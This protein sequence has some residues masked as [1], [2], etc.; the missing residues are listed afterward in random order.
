M[1][2]QVVAILAGEEAPAEIVVAEIVVAEIVVAEEAPEEEHRNGMVS[3]LLW[4]VRS[5]R[6]L[7]L[8]C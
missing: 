5:L 2:D 4:E 6:L 1:V 3:L 7:P 8:W